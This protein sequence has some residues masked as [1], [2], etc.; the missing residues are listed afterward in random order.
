[1]TRVSLRDKVMLGVVAVLFAA[2]D[3]A[4]FAAGP[5]TT[6]WAGPY[7]GITLLLIGDFSLLLL[8]RLPRAVTWYFIAVSGAIL[9][10]D[11]LS[12][13]L[14]SPEHPLTLMTV[15]IASTIVCGNLV[16]L[17]PRREALTLAGILAVLASRPWEPRWDTLPFG[18]LATVTPVAI[19]LYVQARAQLVQSLRDRAERAERERELLAERARAEERRRLAGEMHDV[20]TH[21]LSLMVLHAGALGVST[22]D[23][24]VAESAEEIRTAGREALQELR[25][26]VGVLRGEGELPGRRAEADAP[27]PARLIAESRAAGM[28][29]EYF[30]DG[31]ADRISPT[32]GR[33]AYR[34]VQE[35]LTNI[36]KHAPGARVRIELHYGED[37]LR[38]RVHNGAPTARPDPALA[39]T[40]SG[41]G[42]LGL[43]QRVDLIGGSLAAGPEDGGGY[44]VD[45]ILPAYVPTAEGAR[46]DSG[47]RRR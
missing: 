32:V 27:D 16:R 19:S 45:A 22:K 35:A 43:R 2:L 14:L 29:V 10:S 11:K 36:R 26:L 3:L 8:P 12:P 6:G 40:G 4:L 31:P 15:P 28:Q 38:L 24:K 5:H 9:V 39:G 42:L 1:M 47:G 44:R 25:D 20:V 33:T 18:L 34:V 21:R 30:V 37:G 17:L 46:H 23:S 41:S 13:G 7:A